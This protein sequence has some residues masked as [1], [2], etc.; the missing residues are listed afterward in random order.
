MQALLNKY[1]VPV[2]RYTSYPTVPYWNAIPPTEREWQASARAVFEATNHLEGISLYIHLPFCES[3]CTYCGCNKRITKNHGVESPYINALLTE[4]KL[5]L[6]LFPEPPRIAELH[7]G[8]GTPTFFSAENLDY[9]LGTILRDC[10]LAHD[11]AL[12]FE[13]H[14]ANTTVEQLEVLYKHGFRRLSLGI[15]DFDPEVQ[16]AIHRHQTPEQVAEVVNNARSIGYTGISFDLVYG[17]PKQHMDG[18]LATLMEVL[19]LRPDRIAYYSYAHVPWKSP[20]QRGYSEADLLCA[21]LKQDLYEAGRLLLEGKG[22]TAIGMDHFALPGDALLLAAEAGALHRN[23]MGYTPHHTAL[24]IALGCSAISDSG[25]AFVQNAKKVEDYQQL[26]A[27][28][29]W[30]IERGHLLTTEDRMVA[31]FIRS[32]MC[33]Y[34]ATACITQQSTP[35]FRESLQRLQPLIND[36]LV[37]VLGPSVE[38]LPLGRP[39]IRNICLAFDARYWAARPAETTFS[40]AV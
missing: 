32:L 17:L 1:N 35:W 20:G 2:P 31:P 9:L 40:R 39:V 10:A 7:L 28:G 25:S 16:K 18:L 13:A 12:S 23:F 15:Q 30:P 6:E 38:V 3:L 11:P 4:W 34:K 37:T 5:Y 19:A 33:T 29:Q 27:A 21:H 26:L 22:Y 14:P 36:G 8:G 24:N